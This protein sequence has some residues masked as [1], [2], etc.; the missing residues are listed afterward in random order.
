MYDFCALADRLAEKHGLYKV[1]K[2]YETEYFLIKDTSFVWSEVLRTFEHNNYIV[3]FNIPNKLTYDEK[4]WSQSEYVY[5][6]AFDRHRM[7]EVLQMDW[8]D[9]VNNQFIQTHFERFP[10]IN[11]EDCLDKMLELARKDLN[12]LIIDNKKSEIKGAGSKYI[13]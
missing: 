4:H 12:E 5:C 3:F 9:V 8:P 10:Y 6:Y 11:I 1:D 2:D 7:S 13:L